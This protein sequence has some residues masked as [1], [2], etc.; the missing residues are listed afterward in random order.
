MLLDTDVFVYDLGTQG[1]SITKSI[2]SS[3]ILIFYHLLMG[4]I[5]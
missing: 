4:C 1:W 5:I 3:G 2:G